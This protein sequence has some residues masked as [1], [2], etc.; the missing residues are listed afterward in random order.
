MAIS[1]TKNVEGY[2]ELYFKLKQYKDLFE[3]EMM[4]KHQK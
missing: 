2:N 3:T 4:L 1:E